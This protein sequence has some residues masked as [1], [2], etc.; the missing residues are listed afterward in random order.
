MFCSTNQYVVLTLIPDIKLLLSIP[1]GKGIC[2]QTRSL[3]SSVDTVTMLQ[4]KKAAGPWFDY[5]Q[6][7]EIWL[8]PE[9]FRLFLE[10]TRPPIQ[11]VPCVPSPG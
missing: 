9:V 2:Q 6:G 11:C 8:F 5:L 10:P 7:Q 3:D 1:G 4:D